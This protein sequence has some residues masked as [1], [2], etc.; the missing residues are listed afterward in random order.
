MQSRPLL[1]AKKQKMDKPNL[2]IWKTQNSLQSN[3]FIPENSSLKNKLKE[4]IIHL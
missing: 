2:K 4:Q 3:K 1:T